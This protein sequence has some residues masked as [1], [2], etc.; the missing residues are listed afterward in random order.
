M[1]KKVTLCAVMLE[2][3]M[4]TLIYS[5]GNKSVL[6]LM[7]ANCEKHGFARFAREAMVN[8]TSIN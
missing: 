6:T 2:K 7:S 4:K 8:F 3:T 5:I 1:E